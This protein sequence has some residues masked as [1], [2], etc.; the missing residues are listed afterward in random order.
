M[1]IHAKCPYCGHALSAPDEMA[2]KKMK[3]PNCGEK[4]V[5]LPEE[6]RKELE[7]RYEHERAKERARIVEAR[8]DALLGER[9]GPSYYDNARTMSRV[10][11][12]AGAILGLA[13]VVV[14]IVFLITDGR[15]ILG[16]AAA[17]GTSW[18]V[19]AMSVFLAFAIIVFCKLASELSH[20]AADVGDSHNDTL[21]VLRELRDI[22]R[23]LSQRAKRR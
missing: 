16:Y 10:M 2:G 21:R 8:R 9:A 17:S 19:L 3:C 15:A 13:V 6:A 4:I 23:G 18:V 1:A 5:A 14:G 12:F 22:M 7:E 20:I 11:F